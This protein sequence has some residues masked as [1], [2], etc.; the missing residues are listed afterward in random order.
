MNN[1][2]QYEYNFIEPSNL[3]T[4]TILMIGRA[5]DKSKRLELGVKAMKY[6]VKELPECEMKIISALYKI[7][8]F[9]SLVKSL[10]IEGNIN[11]VGF[12]LTPEI[13]FRNASLH[14]FPSVSESF[15]LALAETKIYGIPSILIGIDY[16][17]VAKGGTIIIYKDDEKLIAKEAIKILKNGKLRKK[18]GKEARLSMKKF[19]NKLLLKRWIKVLLSIYNGYDYY[20]KLKQNDKEISKSNAVAILKRQFKIIKKNN[21]NFKNIRIKDFINFSFIKNLKNF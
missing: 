13:Y 14:I 15:G 4:K 9:R 1:F 2:I 18:L 7:N 5:Y 21:I 11:F 17:S 19:N 20:Q 16:I 3:S 10:K 6:I 8:N 12:T